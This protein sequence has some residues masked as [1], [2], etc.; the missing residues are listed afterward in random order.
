MKAVLLIILANNDFC[1]FDSAAIT[2]NHKSPP[3]PP[4]SLQDVNQKIMDF[5]TTV[6]TLVILALN[7][8]VQYI[9]NYSQHSSRLISSTEAAAK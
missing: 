3:P 6:K 8:V 9:I 1:T 5:R 4:T 2:P 7:Q